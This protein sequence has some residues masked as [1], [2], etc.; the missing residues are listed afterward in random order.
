MNVTIKTI[1]RVKDAI[2]DSGNP[3]SINHIAT[4]EKIHP[5]SVKSAIQE[6]IK[7]DEV[8]RVD[9]STGINLFITNEN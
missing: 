3:V 5:Y 4:K 7:H 2:R 9:N 6:L 1:Q 8:K